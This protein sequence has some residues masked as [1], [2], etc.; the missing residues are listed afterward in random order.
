MEGIAL[1]R[2]SV[3]DATRR[4][5]GRD[6]EVRDL[7]RQS[8]VLREGVQGASSEA[9]E[10]NRQLAASK[11]QLTGVVA[12]LAEQRRRREALERTAGEL[13]SAVNAVKSENIG[14]KSTLGRAAD[15]NARL[16]EKLAVMEETSNDAA[17]VAG[18]I[19]KE[20]QAAEREAQMLRLHNQKAGP[21]RYCS[22]RHRIPSDSRYEG[23]ECVG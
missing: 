13:T 2:P 22:P 21:C 23:P 5:H 19:S 9:E 7:G 14:L 11:A 18:R 3:E 6:A 17:R 1:Y 12:E 16:R 10:Y 15:D 20:A 8:V 4:L